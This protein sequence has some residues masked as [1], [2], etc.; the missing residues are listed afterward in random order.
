MKIYHEVAKDALE[1]I[2]NGGIK[3]SSRGIKG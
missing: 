1:S 3:R 2:L